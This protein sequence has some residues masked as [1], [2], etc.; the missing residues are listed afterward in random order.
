VLS[1]LDAS[2]CCPSGPDQ[3]MTGQFELDD[4]E[5]GTGGYGR[6]IRARDVATGEWVAAKIISMGRMKRTAIEKEV[7]LLSM[8]HHANIIGIRGHEEH[9]RN[10]IIYMEMAAKGELFTRVVSNGSLMENQALP[11]FK[12]IV[13]AVA[14]MHDQGVVHRDLKLENVLLDANDHCKVCDFGLAHVYERQSND[15]IVFTVLR[16]VCGSKSYA[17][18]EVLEGRGY[19]GFPAD[20]W[21]C[22]ICL[23][24]MLAGFFPLDEASGADWRYERVRNAVASQMSAC[25]TI[26]GFYDRPCVLSPEV[27]QL[28]DGMLGINSSQ[29]LTLSHVMSHPW[30][31]GE[32]VVVHTGPTYRGLDAASLNAGVHTGPTYRSLDTA[33]LTAAVNLPTGWRAPTYRGSLTGPVAPP[34]LAKQDALFCVDFHMEAT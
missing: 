3:H 6:V 14:Y 32:K 22:A 2:C 17:A 18:P 13:S 21:S 33:S 23:F 10:Y 9:E 12:Q 7:A 16:E 5:L 29:R 1:V 30:M 8:L 19:E 11:Y 20:V 24:A 15:K 28:I 25:Q 4:T 31:K 27:V 34:K 26:F